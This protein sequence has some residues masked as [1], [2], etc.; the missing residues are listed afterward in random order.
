MHRFPDRQL[1]PKQVIM[2]I[3]GAFWGNILCPLM[4]MILS[5]VDYNFYHLWQQEKRT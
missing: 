2:I 4:H 1:S 3:S 5:Q